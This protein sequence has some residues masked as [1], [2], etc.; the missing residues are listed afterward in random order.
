MENPFAPPQ[1]DL[2]APEPGE[3]GPRMPWED[4]AAYPAL[5]ARVMATLRW[6]LLRPAELGPALAAPADVVPPIGFFALLALPVT[7]AAA[8][9]GAF[10]PVQPFWQAWM[11][12]PTPPQPEGLARTIALLIGTLGAPL[13]LALG[14]LIG[15]LLTHAGLWAAGATRQKLGLMVTFRTLLYGSAAGT[16]VAFPLTLAQFLPGMTG[17]AAQVVH[18]LFTALVLTTWYGLLYARAHRTDTWRGVLG[19][20][21]PLLAFLLCCGACLGSLFAFGGEAFREALSKG[22][23]GGM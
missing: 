1:A 2:A 21:L 15:G 11:G 5:G 14:V 9:L 13:G 7:I 6:L 12:L 4:R 16:L 18:T 17:Q 19:A 3:A 10:F 23:Q 22:L 8:L 20:W